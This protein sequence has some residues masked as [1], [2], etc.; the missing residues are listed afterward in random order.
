MKKSI[1]KNSQMGYLPVGLDR[2]IFQK[3]I[4]MISGLHPLA[5]T[6][7]LDYEKYFKASDSVGYSY[8]TILKKSLDAHKARLGDKTITTPIQAGFDTSFIKMAMVAPRQ[9]FKPD[10]FFSTA[11]DCASVMF[12]DLLNGFFATPNKLTEPYIVYALTDLTFPTV[13]EFDSTVTTNPYTY[14]SKGVGNPYVGPTY[15]W[16][17]QMIV[18]WGAYANGKNQVLY[19]DASKIIQSLMPIDQIIVSTRNKTSTGAFTYTNS[20][21][22][23]V[24]SLSIA[25]IISIID[26]AITMIQWLESENNAVEIRGNVDGVKIDGYEKILADQLNY[27]NTMTDVVQA[28]L[29]NEKTDHQAKKDEI[30]ALIEQKKK[31]LVLAK[32]AKKESI[33]KMT[34]YV[35]NYETLL[36]AK[37]DEIVRGLVQ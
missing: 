11:W 37:K 14:Y 25:N 5:Q 30:L 8:A 16:N 18:G 36:Q 31:E 21:F 34:D 24:T 26:S 3:R 7:V 35:N 9:V 6:I 4:E 23:N 19:N 29:I 22:Y 10:T 27:L 13:K 12:F 1:K 32:Q 20:N 28:S 2:S 17:Y 33:L 15:W